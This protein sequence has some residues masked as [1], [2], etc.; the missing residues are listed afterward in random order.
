MVNILKI[1]DIQVIDKKI[2]WTQAIKKQIKAIKWAL[3]K[4][5]ITCAIL[6]ASYLAS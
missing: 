4:S 1:N 6:F 3:Y 2:I 5:Y